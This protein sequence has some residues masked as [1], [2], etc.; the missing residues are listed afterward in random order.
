LYNSYN[1]VLFNRIPANL[2]SIVYCT[3]LGH[4]DEKEWNF[5]WERYKESIITI[6][7]VTILSALGCTKNKSLLTQ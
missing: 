2:R 6:E 4:G 5:L 7:Q 1:N 3:A